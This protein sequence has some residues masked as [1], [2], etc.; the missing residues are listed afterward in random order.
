MY[1]YTWLSAVISPPVIQ[2]INDQPG[3]VLWVSLQQ[4]KSE[5]SDVQMNVAVSM[6]QSAHRSNH[7]RPLYIY[8]SVLWVSLQNAKL[9]VQ[10]CRAVI[11]ACAVQ[12]RTA[13]VLVCAVQ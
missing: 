6:N 11:L 12:R 13:V 1:K 8:R 5:V 7:Q 3:P 9:E 2:I 10:R 4:A